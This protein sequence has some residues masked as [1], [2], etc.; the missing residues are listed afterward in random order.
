MKIMFNKKQAL[1][2]TNGIVVYCKRKNWHEC[3]AH[4]HLSSKKPAQHKADLFIQ[5]SISEVLTVNEYLNASEEYNRSM[6]QWILNENYIADRISEKLPAGYT[7]EVKGNSD[8]TVSDI[9]IYDSKGEL[10]TFVEAK[11]EKSQC[12]QFVLTE[13]DNGKLTATSAL[14]NPYTVPLTEALNRYRTSYP[15]DI[16]LDPAKLTDEEKANAYEW[17]KHHYKRLGASHI[18]VT[19]DSNTY[20]RIMPIDEIE[21]D[22]DITLNMPRVKQS[23]SVKLPKTH[24]QAFND[25]LASSK[26]VTNGYTYVQNEK[27]GLTYITVQ[28]KELT[29]DEQ[30]IDADNYF[31]SKVGEKQGNFVYV[32]R[33][34]SN[35]KNINEVLGFTY[36]HEK[37]DYGFS[38][39]NNSLLNN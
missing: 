13:D 29:K 30:Y 26:L 24:Q 1:Y 17:I 12:G 32:A 39:L 3:S 27:D 31:L 35:T 38:D 4:K 7:A 11:S 21:K 5:D 9:A 14:D 16:K 6:P 8:S 23:G 22:V 18:A 36:T 25:A 20:V 37:S 2:D 34:R 28:G 15:N 10:V 33:K 19:D